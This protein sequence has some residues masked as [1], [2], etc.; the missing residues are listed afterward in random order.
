MD[1]EETLV[2]FLS[3]CIYKEQLQHIP[4][5]HCMAAGTVV[6]FKCL[7]NIKHCFTFFSF[8][9][10]FVKRNS[11]HIFVKV[12]LYQTMVQFWY[13]IKSYSGIYLILVVLVKSEHAKQDNVLFFDFKCKIF[14]F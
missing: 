6:L 8:D 10:H 14:S 11:F 2:C 13:K 9:L 5:F 4:D 3:W 7:I 12:K 1:V